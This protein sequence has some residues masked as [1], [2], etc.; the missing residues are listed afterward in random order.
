MWRRGSTGCWWTL[1]R[2]EATAT[3]ATAR[4]GRPLLREAVGGLEYHE[5]VSRSGSLAV[6]YALGGGWPRGRSSLVYGATS[7]GKTTLCLL[8][9]AINSQQGRNVG[10]F[11]VENALSWE[12]AEKLGCVREHFYLFQPQLKV[13][14]DGSTV[15]S[16]FMEQ[17]LDDLLL[18]FKAGAFDLIILDSLDALVPRTI[19]EGSMSDQTMGLAA[20]QQSNFFRRSA[21]L[22]GAHNTALIAINQLRER[23]GLTYGS[24]E[25]L[26]GGKAQMFYPSIRVK[27]LKAAKEQIT[28]E[29]G[30]ISAITHKG[31]VEKNKTARPFREFELTV[32]QRPFYGVDLIP[33]LV[34]LG[35]QLGV[36]TNREGAGY[37]KGIAVFNGIELGNGEKQMIDF[38][39]THPS[40]QATIERAVRAAMDRGPQDDQPMAAADKFVDRAQP[41]EQQG[42]V[43]DN[44]MKTQGGER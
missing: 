17:I 9:A 25:Y 31:K 4:R 27:M 1:P 35:K 28:G 12:W 18:L 8:A 6:D 16:G 14:G 26:P 21:G 40:I 30:E 11:D 13:E 32:R 20:K 36:F 19:L 41:S 2:C 44:G 33:E 42:M 10:Y 7:Y 22:L 23:I 24:P 43:T 34:E 38:L 15:V 37:S 39:R 3:A 5:L 29:D